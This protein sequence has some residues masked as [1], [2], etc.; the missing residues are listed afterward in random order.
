MHTVL[1]WVLYKLLT[2]G[3][4]PGNYPGV[5]WQRGAYCATQEWIP[6]HRKVQ[7][8]IYAQEEAGKLASLV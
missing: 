2:L 4:R 8:H 6:M 1:T 3:P 7:E 5:A